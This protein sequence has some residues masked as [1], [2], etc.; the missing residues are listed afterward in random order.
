MQTTQSLPPRQAPRR[1]RQ[2]YYPLLLL[3]IQKDLRNKD[4]PRPLPGLLLLLLLLC[5][6]R[7]RR[8]LHLPQERSSQSLNWALHPCRLQIWRRLHPQGQLHHLRLLHP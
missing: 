8:L 2:V 4:K 1:P 6:L 7:K 3:H 5:R